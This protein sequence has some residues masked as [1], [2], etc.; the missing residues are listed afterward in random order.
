[1]FWV[2]KLSKPFYFKGNPFSKIAYTINSS[3]PNQVSFM[4]IIYQSMI[5]P[6]MC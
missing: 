3:A 1:M 5:V 2:K 4:A 6:L